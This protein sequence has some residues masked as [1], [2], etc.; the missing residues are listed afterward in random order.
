[1][2][3]PK[4]QPT[5]QPTPKP[6]I[7]LMPT[8]AADLPIDEESE[9]AVLGS[10][11]I[12][13]KLYHLAAKII[14]NSS[15]FFFTKNSI[16]W[17]AITALVN[18]D[19]PIDSV[20]LVGHLTKAGTINQVGSA[21]RLT[22]LVANTPPGAN[23]EAYA[24]IVKRASIRRQIIQNADSLKAAAL[25]E[26]QPT[27]SLE[28]LI[29]QANQIFATLKTERAQHISVDT[30][31]HVDM[32][33]AAMRNPG[34]IGINTGLRGLDDL[35]TGLHKR[36]MIVVGGIS[37]H[38]KTA[39]LLE[40]AI[41]AA[42]EGANV[43][44]FNVAD[45]D[46]VDVMNR[47]ATM[48]SGISTKKL[49]KGTI[50]QSEHLR[51]IE[52]M[53]ALDKLPIYRKSEKGMSPGRI[54]NECKTLKDRKGGTVRPDIIIIDYIQ[55]MYLSTE[56]KKEHRINDKRNE[57]MV[58]SQALTKLADGKHFNCP[59]VVGAQLRMDSRKNERPGGHNVQESKNIYQHCDV[60]VTVYRPVLINP[61]TEF[62]SAVEL[63]V[64]KNKQTGEIATI[65]CYFDRS[66]A[67]IIN[68]E[69][70]NIDLRSRGGFND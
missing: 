13:P 20:T 32:V 31:A 62:P 30:N 36:K 1:M 57:L 34:K 21:M 64:D 17:D 67:R 16:L 7:I 54:M 65:N 9:D 56:Y 46:D 26:T 59:V 27:E 19:T 25:D 53:G 18:E 11:L 22:E 29:E 42:T 68:G 39:L 49:V 38:G 24:E 4:S 40:I 61:A 33:E 12:N 55:E 8:H 41:N 51:Y 10:I 47:L 5:P 15:A 35:L 48:M 28:P 60:F 14:P 2:N 6:N 37:H 23:V 70:H 45:G 69:T 66:A 44:L 52:A 50:S 43:A 3:K 63:I 58:I